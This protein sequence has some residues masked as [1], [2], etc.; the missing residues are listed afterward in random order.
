VLIHWLIPTMP[1]TVAFAL[2]AVISPTDAVAVSA[3]T[4][5]QAMPAKTLHVLQGESL[6]NDASGLVALKF[7]IAATLTGS[8]SWWGAGRGS[9]GWRWAAP[10]WACCWAGA[11]ARREG[12]H[13]PRG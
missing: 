6:L 12:G 8:F 13:A 4:R 11:L 1:L 7:A 2:A 10:A 5:G 3:I 9:C